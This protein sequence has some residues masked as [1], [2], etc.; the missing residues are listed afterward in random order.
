VLTFAGV[1]SSILFWLY[2]RRGKW[3]T[4]TV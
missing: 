3:L 1:G 4:A 2:Y